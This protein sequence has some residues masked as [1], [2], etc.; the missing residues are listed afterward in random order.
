MSLSTEQTD[1]FELK[2]LYLGNVRKLLIGHNESGRGCGWFCQQVTVQSLDAPPPDKK[3]E[4]V[5]VCNR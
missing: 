4:V 2:S 5:F 1:R 3:P